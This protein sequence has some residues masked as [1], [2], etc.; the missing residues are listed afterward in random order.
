MSGRI[1]RK[2]KQF[3]KNIAREETASFKRPK[4]GNARGIKIAEL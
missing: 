4:K 3:N 1:L 2:H